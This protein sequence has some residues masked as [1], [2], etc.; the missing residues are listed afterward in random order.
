MNPTPERAARAYGE[1]RAAFI[2]AVSAAYAINVCGSGLSVIDD[3]FITFRHATNFAEHGQL[4]L[5]LGERVEGITNLLW[6][7]VLAGVYRLFAT[8][9]AETAVVLSLLAVPWALLRV[10]QIGLRLTGKDAWGALA[11][12]L[13]AL[14]PHFILASTNGLETG[15]FCALLAELCYRVVRQH[16][17]ACGVLI[18]LLFLTRPE[19]ALLLVPLLLAVR[20]ATGRSSRAWPAVAIA[21]AVVLGATAFRY[22]S[23]G[24]PLPNSIVA[25]SYP[26]AQT[27]ELVLGGLKYCVGFAAVNGYLLLPLGALLAYLAR[28]KSAPSSSKALLGFCVTTLTLIWLVAMR[29]GGD[30]M[31]HHRLFLQYGPIWSLTAILVLS[32]AGW[33]ARWA[34]LLCLWPLALLTNTVIGNR[35]HFFRIDTN[36]GGEFYAEATR[37]LKGQLRAEDVVSAEAIGYISFHLP[38]T[39]FHDPLGLNDAYIARHGTPAI[40]FGKEDPVYTLAVVAPAVALWQTGSHLWRVPRAVLGNYQIRRFGPDVG[41][42][43]NLVCLRKDRLPTLAQAFADWPIVDVTPTVPSFVVHLNASKVADGA[44]R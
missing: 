14:N 7:L 15:L 31:P 2:A 21:C 39:R 4:V 27:P 10:Y 28:L 13:L 20:L 22:L 12:L 9:M 41:W 26:F 29:N 1:H 43:S 17:S 38:S 19:G 37:R 24:Q 6:A 30:W 23:Y 40:R 18:G 3:A 36:A 25:K 32:E 42:H 11:A 16:Y 33:H 44:A 35:G 8:P 5:N 34:A